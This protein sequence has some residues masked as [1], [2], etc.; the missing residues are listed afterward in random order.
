ML[1]LYAAPWVHVRSTSVLSASR[2]L[3]PR[4][5]AESTTIP[6]EPFRWPKL[7][8]FVST[9]STTTSAIAVPRRIC[10]RGDERTIAATT[11][12]RGTSGRRYL[13]SWFGWVA[14]RPRT[15]A[16]ERAQLRAATTLGLP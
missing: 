4:S 3:E 8:K 15:R 10:E 5:G 11:A 6:V 2:R 16:T 1:I 12:T 9:A 7:F 13:G 14:K